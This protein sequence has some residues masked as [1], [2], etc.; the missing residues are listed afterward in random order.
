MAEPIDPSFADAEL[1]AFIRAVRQDPGPPAR[2]VGAVEL[3]RAQRLRAEAR[4]P[5]PE[6]DH[7]EDLVVGS[8]DVGPGL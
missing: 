1:A 6:I 4:P 5:G 8:A 3:R 7:V 2:A